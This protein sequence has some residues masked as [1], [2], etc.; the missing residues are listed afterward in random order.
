MVDEGYSSINRTADGIEKRTGPRKDY[1]MNKQNLS[2]L[3]ESTIRSFSP[4]EIGTALLDLVPVMI[5]KK[6]AFNAWSTD[7]EKFLLDE[8]A[9]IV[10]DA[11]IFIQEDGQKEETESAFKT[12]CRAIGKA[13]MRTVRAERKERASRAAITEATDDEGNTIE[14]ISMV[15]D[16]R[17]LST[18]SAAIIAADIEIMIR[19]HCEKYG[20][21]KQEARQYFKAI[22]AGMNT[23]NAGREA[24]MT[25]RQER[26]AWKTWSEYKND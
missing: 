15:E 9:S 14:V 26:N 7:T 12:I 17:S 21:T 25:R 22:A 5:R 1:I 16:T 6:V 10:A 19:E 4:D 13:I 8:S 18:A 24:G 23:S 11:Y 20:C 2:S 3:K